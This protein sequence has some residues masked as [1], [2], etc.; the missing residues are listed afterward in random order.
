MLLRYRLQHGDWK[1]GDFLPTLE[2]FMTEYGVSRVTMRMALAELEQDGLIERRRGFGTRV[3]ADIT[4]ERWLILPNEW[5]S[6]ISHVSRLHARVVELS[7]GYG[8]PSFNCDC[9]P[10]A[11]EYWWSRRINWTL[12]SP[13]S[14]LTVYLAKPWFKR[15][16]AKYVAG[17]ILP[18]LERHER[19]RIASARQTMTIGWADAD[20]ARHLQINVGTPIAEVR[21]VVRDHAGVAA[22]LAEV[23]YP[24]KHLQQ[25]TQLLP[26]PVV[27]SLVAED[28]AAHTALRI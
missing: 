1:L 22:Y 13:Y 16:K 12:T 19:G 24:A 18:V 23:I 3:I 5:S 14:L 28:M 21:R 2:D 26:E 6:L 7:S 8:R 27:S 11:A 17:A 15:H 4:Q 25:E 10:L 9:A 20:V